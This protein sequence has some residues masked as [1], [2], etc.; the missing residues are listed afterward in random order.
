MSEFAQFAADMAAI[1][2]HGNEVMNICH[3]LALKAGWWSELQNGQLFTSEERIRMIPEKLLLI[4][5]EVSEACEAHR[6][7]LMDEKLPHRSGLEVELADAV[8]RIMDLAGAL[9]LDIGGAMAEKLRYNKGRKDH[10][11]AHR[12]AAGG[13]AF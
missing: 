1:E 8:I 4:H 9:G 5:S 10:T 2:V 7:G 6:K 12:R 13:K 11:P 3:D